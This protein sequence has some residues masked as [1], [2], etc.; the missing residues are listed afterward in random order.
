MA[1]VDPGATEVSNANPLAARFTALWIVWAGLL[2]AA[3]VVGSQ[4]GQH[5]DFW[6]TALR[7]ASSAMLVVTAWYAW[8]LWRGT[9]VA[10]FAL[11]IAVGMTL[12]AI[13]DLFNAGW[14]RFVPLA[15]PT[16]GGIVAFGLGHMAYI[17]GSLYL[18]R[19]A[20]L[21]NRQA[22]SISI[23]GWQLIGLAA[24]YGV[25][26]LGAQR[27]GLVWPALGYTLLL[28]GTAG[29]TAGLA[30]QE[31]RLFPLAL[32]AA[33]FLMSDLILAFELFR[34]PF[35]H[36]T[37]FVWLTYGPGQ[38]LIVFSILSAALVLRARPTAT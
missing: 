6:P 5:G 14:L 10:T 9:T 33:L 25:V 27:R 16:L 19:A 23:V 18:A 22:M 2:A 21:R 12:G 11:A 29:V 26:M 36:D 34:G 15:D 35:A 37:L 3:L 1:N 17:A 7:M 31:R 28:A 20:G 8:S 4:L 32:G 24:W 30:L 38:M 13:G